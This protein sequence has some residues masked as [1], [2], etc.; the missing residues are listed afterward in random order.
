MPGVYG[1]LIVILLYGIPGN[2]TEP[3]IWL[4]TQDDIDILTDTSRRILV[5][6]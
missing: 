3:E 6:E 4:I 2:V 1:G 5:Q